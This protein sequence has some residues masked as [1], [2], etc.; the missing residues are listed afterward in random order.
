MR[1]PPNKSSSLEAVG[2]LPASDVKC[3][4]QCSGVLSVLMHC[5]LTWKFLSAQGKIGERKT[6]FD[7]DQSPCDMPSHQLEM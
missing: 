6:G 4:Q 3:D 1:F 5:H 2:L 7:T